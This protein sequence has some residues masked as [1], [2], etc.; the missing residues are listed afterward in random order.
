VVCDAN[1]LGGGAYYYRV[2]PD[3]SITNVTI[4]SDAQPGTQL[5]LAIEQ[6][7]E[8]GHDGPLAVGP[9]GTMWAL[10]Q[11][12]IIELTPGGQEILTLDV[13]INDPNQLVSN[14][15]GALDAIGT[16]YANDAQGEQ[17]LQC[18]S[19]VNADGSETTIADLPN[20]DGYNNSLVHWAVMDRAGNV[21]LILD[22]T[23][24]PVRQY[25]AEVSP[26]GA[27]KTF[28][29][30]VPGDTAPVPVSPA[31]PVI[32]PNGGLWTPDQQDAGWKLVQVVPK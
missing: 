28:P 22:T 20:Y 5:S 25:Y 29:F 13:G 2:S 3:G 16:C 19:R 4:V 32:T 30:T 15:S 14:G 31:L 24:P 7:P 9:G 17:T 11:G 1:I 8:A 23:Q 12:D 18:V 21:W 10:D 26:G 6:L 27:V